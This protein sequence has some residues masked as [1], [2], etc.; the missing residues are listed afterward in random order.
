MYFQYLL[1]YMNGEEQKTNQGQAEQ[2]DAV[3]DGFIAQWGAFGSQWGIN[4]TMAQIHALLMTGIGAMS[5]DEVMEKLGISRGNAHTN[6][7]DL[8]GWGLVRIIVKKGERKE[9]FEAEKDVWK[10][11]TIILRERQRRE[12]DPALELL[13]DC[14]EETKGLKGAEAEA[15]R[16]QVKE[17]EQFV[18]FARNIGGKV[19]KL[20]YG[21]AMKLAAKFLG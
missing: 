6:L 21:P 1:K 20:S 11:F 7:K 3:R 14:Q 15:F 9:F 19:N 17:L 8:V 4:R 13:R 16:D 5:T 2:L 18:G 12:I 10:I